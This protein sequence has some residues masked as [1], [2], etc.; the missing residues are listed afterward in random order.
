[1]QAAAG[2]RPTIDWQTV[3][4]PLPLSPTMPKVSPSRSV[5]LSPSTAL[6]TRVPPNVT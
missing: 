4:L 5:K 2:N 1:M 6:T 3:V